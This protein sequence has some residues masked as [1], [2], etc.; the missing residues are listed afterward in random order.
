MAATNAS[1]TNAARYGTVRDRVLGLGVVLADGMVIGAGG[2]SMKTYT[3]YNLTGI[4]F[5]S[6]G[7]LACSPSLFCVCSRFLSIEATGRV[8]VAIIRSGMQI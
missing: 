7:T 1:G 3:G 6:E 2:M 4:F 5:V 8:A